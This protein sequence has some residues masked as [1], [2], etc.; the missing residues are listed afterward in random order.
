[1]ELARAFLSLTSRSGYSGSSNKT[2]LTLP[3]SDNYSVCFRNRVQAMSP[4]GKPFNH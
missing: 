2:L 4:A 3:W 1:M